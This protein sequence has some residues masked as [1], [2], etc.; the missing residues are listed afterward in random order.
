MKLDQP[1]NLTRVGIDA[2]KNKLRLALRREDTLEADQK[3]DFVWR[4]Q[5]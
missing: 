5:G 2:V 3:E 4:W 1:L